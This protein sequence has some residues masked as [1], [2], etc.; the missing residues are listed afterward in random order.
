MTAPVKRYKLLLFD[1]DDTLFDYSKAEEQALAGAFAESGLRFDKTAHLET[2]QRHNLKAWDEYGRGLISAQTLR[3]K[4][5]ELFFKESGI[6]AIPEP[7]SGIYLKHLSQAAFMIDGAE[8]VIEYLAQNYELAVV[9]N[10]LAEV[11]K[12][13]FRCSPLS[14][15]FRHLIV[16]EEAGSPKPSPEFFAYAMKVIGN[17]EKKEILLIGDSMQSDI[18]GGMNFGI[19]TCWYNPKGLVLPPE[20]RPVFIISKLGELKDI[21]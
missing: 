14:R 1:A 3:I 20:A 19:D 9:T 5:F 11:Q 13:R 7:F 17:F 10:G 4:R 18:L 16:S 15:W 6:E 2:Y 8:E 21:L 12:E